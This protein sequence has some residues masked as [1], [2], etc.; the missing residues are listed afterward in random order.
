MFPRGYHYR[1]WGV[2]QRLPVTFLA[3]QF[4]FDNFVTLGLQPPPPGFR[5]VR[6]GP[7]LFLVDMRTGDIID[8]AY[9]VFY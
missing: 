6:F 7:D 1:H 8:A 4:F 5:W 9:G 3:S 2:G